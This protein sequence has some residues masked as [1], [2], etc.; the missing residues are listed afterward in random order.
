MFA[1]LAALALLCCPPPGATVR[2]A[3]YDVYAE[4]VDAADTAAMLDALHA[5]LTKHFGR[6]PKDRLRVEVYATKDAFDA[7]L[8]RDKVAAV[9]SGG[10]YAPETKAAY[11]WV[12]PSEYWTR[13]LIL[14]EATHQFH[15]LVAGGNTAVDPAWYGEGIA[16]YFGGH[17]WDGKELKVGVVP[18]VSLED[19]PAQAL[20][21]FG[22][23]KENLDGIARGDVACER[24]VGW[25][26]VSFLSA[27][28]PARWKALAAQLDAH[29]KPE[30]AWEKSFGRAGPD[31]VKA[32]KDWL[33]SHQQPLRIVWVSWQERGDAI[34]GKSASGCG[35]LFR[36]APDA[37][38]AAIELRSGTLRAGLMFNYRD[39]DSYVTLQVTKDKASVVRWTKGV[40]TVLSAIDIDPAVPPVA[41]Y[42]RDGADAVVSVNG[43]E[44][45]RLPAEGEAGLWLENCEVFFRLKK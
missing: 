35:A 14:H 32:F 7:A 20:K 44:A 26:M 1:A 5:H 39:N 37:F 18:A 3:R 8:K 41:S 30:K 13:Q 15:L 43:R 34:E 10:Y 17:N 25:A 38:E 23:L 4:G 28:Q 9:Q 21:Q 40:W 11:L 12:Q 42:R 29:K 45:G 33:A 16:E 22:E 24:P 36:K 2:T 31:M 19:Y 6:A 27:T